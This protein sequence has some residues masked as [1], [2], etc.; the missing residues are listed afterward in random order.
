MQRSITSIQRGTITLS[1]FD[2]VA[3][4]DAGRYTV[5]IAG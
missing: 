4:E 5:S 1:L 3:T 2:A